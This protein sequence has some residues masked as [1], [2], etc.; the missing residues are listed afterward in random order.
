MVTPL[1]KPATLVEPFAKTGAKNTIPV[2]ASATPGLA[3]LDTGFPPLTMVAVGAGG[4]PPSGLDF[5]GIFNWI[6]QHTAWLNA[7]GQYTFD[8]TLAAFIGGY[9]VGMVLISTDGLSSYVNVLANNSTDFNATPASIGVSWMPYGGAAVA[10]TGVTTVATTGG[11][12]TLSGLQSSRANINV[13]GA[14]TSNA[15]L[16]FPDAI[17]EWEVINNTTGAFTVTC[18]SV[19]TAGVTIAQGVAD[20]LVFNGVA[21]AYAQAEVAT[22]TPGNSSLLAAN[23]AFVATAI[24]TAIAAALVN[25]ALTG[26]PTVPDRAANNNSS[27]IANTRYVDAALGAVNVAVLPQYKNANFTAGTSGDYWIDTSAGAFTMLL[28]DPPVNQNPL[29]IQ[30]ITG[31]WS[32]LPLTINAGTKTFLGGDTTL[33]CDASGEFFEIWYNGSTWRLV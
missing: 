12:I 18:K 23:T 28:Q 16:V 25:T 24:S 32:T 3:S 15:I 10:A 27:L 2:T 31:S 29:R 13:T 21:I 7:G 17:R 8:A 19:S 6:T 5:N 33:I 14:L 9:P 11:T 26:N 30:D 4:V 22:A 1:V 20:A